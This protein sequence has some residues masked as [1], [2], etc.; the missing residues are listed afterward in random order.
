MQHLAV[1]PLANERAQQHARLL[2]SLRPLELVGREVE[3]RLPRDYKVSII[4]AGGHGT[5][6]GLVHVAA[7]GLDRRPARG[8]ALEQRSIPEL[9]E[10]PLFEASQDGSLS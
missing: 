7:A 3:E 8:F 1:Q 9:G 10:Q 6:I 4:V 5:A 2:P